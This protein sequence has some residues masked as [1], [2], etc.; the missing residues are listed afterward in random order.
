MRI[1]VFYADEILVMGIVSVCGY[2]NLRV[3]NFAILLNSRKLS[4]RENLVFYS[5][6]LIEQTAKI[7]D[8]QNYRI[9]ST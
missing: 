8:S 3:F 1:L 7:W 9:Y 2:K 6:H 4:A 5:S